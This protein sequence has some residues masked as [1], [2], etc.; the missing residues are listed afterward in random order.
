MTDLLSSFGAMR[1]SSSMIGI[2]FDLAAAS[3]AP[4][5]GAATL[6]TTRR[7]I[8][9]CRRR[10]AAAAAGPSPQIKPRQSVRVG[11]VVHESGDG[12]QGASGFG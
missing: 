5:T 4:L 7:L 11:W 9:D 12:A 10:V 1:S 8:P 2:A 6:I 3:N